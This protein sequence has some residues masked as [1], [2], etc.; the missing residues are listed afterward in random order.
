M[1]KQKCLRVRLR[2][3]LRP[4]STPSPSPLCCGTV[5]IGPLCPSRRGWT[6]CPARAR[7][8]WIIRGA[9]PL[10]DL[11]KGWE[12]GGGKRLNIKCRSE[13]ERVITLCPTNPPTPLP[14]VMELSRSELCPSRHGW[15]F[16]PERARPSWI[17]RGACP[18]HDHEVRKKGTSST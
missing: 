12:A 6:F 9:C 4:S 2:P 11:K 14:C 3:W 16:C 10:H 18:L 5:E 13:R 1:K 15:T 17:I 8:S 7:P